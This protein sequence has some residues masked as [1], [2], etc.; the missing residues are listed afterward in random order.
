MDLQT[1]INSLRCYQQSQLLPTAAIRQYKT[2]NNL[3]ND[4]RN[5][6]RKEPCTMPSIIN[7]EPGPQKPLRTFG[8]VLEEFLE[9]GPQNPLRT[10]HSNHGTSA[11]LEWHSSS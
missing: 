4:L 10:T 2:E 3:S 8:E 6:L 5:K 11:I 7:L 9:P 1:R